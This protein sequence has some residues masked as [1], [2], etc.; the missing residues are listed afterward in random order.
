MDGVTAVV[1]E[2]IALDEAVVADGIYPIASQ[3]V[4]F[5][6]DDFGIAAAA[7][8][9]ATEPKIIAK[10]ADTGPLVCIVASVKFHH[11]A[12]CIGPVQ[13]HAAKLYAA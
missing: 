12:G 4:Y 8:A 5:V 1:M 9:K 2:Y 11:I 3:I 6:A 13:S 10:K 7:D